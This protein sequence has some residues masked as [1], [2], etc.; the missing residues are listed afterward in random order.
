M[1]NEKTQNEQIILDKLFE[2]FSNIEGSV[3]R[4]R[5]IELKVSKDHVLSVLLYAK[6]QLS[7]FHLSHISCVD[8]LED[9]QFEL[10]YILWSHETQMQ[11]FVKILIDRE[12]PVAPNIDYIWRHANTYEREIREMYGI[13]FKGLVGEQEFILE[14]WEGMPP[15][16]RDFD[17]KEYAEETFFDR[18]GREDAKDVREEIIERSREELPDFAKKY[19]RD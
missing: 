19:S 8:W 4:E 5:R 13:E 2:S 14:D 6:E 17:T 12:K 10:I 16:R 7:F 3:R 9:N 18:P 1:S 11:L 15:M